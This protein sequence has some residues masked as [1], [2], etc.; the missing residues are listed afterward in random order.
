VYDGTISWGWTHRYKECALHDGRKDGRRARATGTCVSTGRALCQSGGHDAAPGIRLKIT[1]PPASPRSEAGLEAVPGAD[2]DAPHVSVG[3]KSAEC[4]R[5]IS[6]GNHSLSR[7]TCTCRTRVLLAEADKRQQPSAKR[8][9]LGNGRDCPLREGGT[10]KPWRGS[11]TSRKVR[12]QKKYPMIV[13][14]TSGIRPAPQVIS[15][16]PSAS[17]V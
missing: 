8:V 15:P 10:G 13:T 12:P 16:R 14:T 5:V 7:R 4:R 9:H 17:T 3:R 2:D 6:R 1:N 11:C